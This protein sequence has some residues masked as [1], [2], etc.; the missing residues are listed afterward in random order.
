MI[1]FCSCAAS[2]IFADS[3]ENCIGGIL[4][5]HR[6][7]LLASQIHPYVSMSLCFP[8]LMIPVLLLDLIV[9]I[10]ITRMTHTSSKKEVHRC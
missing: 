10:S 5:L 6:S 7:V 1:D 8:Q 4:L 9:L 2:L 3:A